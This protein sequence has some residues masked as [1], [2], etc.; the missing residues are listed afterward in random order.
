[1]AAPYSG[2]R[3]LYLR[4]EEDEALR[5]FAAESGSSQNAVIRLGLRLVVGLPVPSWALEELRKRLEVEAGP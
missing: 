2:Y 4:S 3:S 1:V 5:R